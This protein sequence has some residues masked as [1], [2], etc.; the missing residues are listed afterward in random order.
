[1]M[2]FQPRVV[3]D[4]VVAASVVYLGDISDIS[5]IFRG[6]RYFPRKI[7]QHIRH[8]KNIV[9]HSLTREKLGIYRKSKE[10]VGLLAKRAEKVCV[11]GF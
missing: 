7:S 4:V 10:S 2:M 11:K 8:F 3:D 9:T 5:S 6:G 1:M